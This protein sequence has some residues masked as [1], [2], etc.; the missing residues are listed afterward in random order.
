VI[1]ALRSRLEDLAAASLLEEALE[2]LTESAAPHW[3]G[4]T[5]ADVPEMVRDLARDRDDYRRM[6][7]AYRVDLARLERELEAFED[8]AE[9]CLNEAQPIEVGSIVRLKEKRGTVS[10]LWTGDGNTA[11]VDVDWPTHDGLTLTNWEFLHNIEPVTSC[12][13]RE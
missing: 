7:E 2:A 1:S 10:R 8:A 5:I 12:K 6:A 11:R 9:G 13:G 4:T 3:S